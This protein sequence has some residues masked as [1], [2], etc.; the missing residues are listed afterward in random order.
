MLGP[1]GEGVGAGM[2]TFYGEFYGD[3]A[4][5]VGRAW[6]LALGPLLLI[7]MLRAIFISPRKPET[8]AQV[9]TPPPD[10]KPKNLDRRRAEP[11]LGD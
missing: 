8:I 6:T 11:K 2:G 1:Y 4:S 5:G 3:L 9:Q 10:T 7:S